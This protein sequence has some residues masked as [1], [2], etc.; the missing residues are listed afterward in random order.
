MAD[1]IFL[2]NKKLLADDVTMFRDL[3]PSVLLRWIQE[4]SIAHTEAL[5]A[6]RAKTL[7]KGVLW[8]V[9]RIKLQASRLPDYDENVTLKSWAGP[10]MRVL[11]PRHYVLEDEKG[12]AIVRASAVW[13][14]MD[15]KERRMAF[16]DEYGVA[17][18]G[19]S[20]E[21]ELSLPTGVSLAEQKNSKT[22]EVA[23]SQVDINKHMNNSKYLDEMEDVLGGEYLRT[24]QLATLEIEF[25]SEIKLGE[26]VTLS[27]TADDDSV[28]MIGFAKNAPCFELKATF[29]QRQ[30]K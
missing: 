24:H 10:T 6:G 12:N 19:T 20:Q 9:A 25:K 8:V 23:Y 30:A 2:T 21:G 22:F 29:R 7:D 13:L 14:L 5:G 17:V 15:A 18:P 1:L 4:I 27:Y 16:P 3:R 28:E 26:K 11:F